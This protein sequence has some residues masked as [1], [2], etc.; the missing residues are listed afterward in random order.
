MIH[1]IE[2]NTEEWFQLR[3]GKITASNFSKIMANNGKAF[4]NPAKDYAARVAI[5]SETF[6]TIETFT[7]DW[8]ERGKMLEDQARELYKGYSFTDVLP[9]GFCEKGRFG[10]SADGLPG[11]GLVEFKYVK[12]NTHFERL[13]KG[14]FD[15]AYKWQIN[16]QMW[17]YDRP[18]CD[19]V[20]YC[21]DFPPEK[22]LYVFRVERNLEEE[23]IMIK[24]LGL[25][26]SEVDHYTKVLQS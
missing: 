17:V 21:P 23:L 4:G 6:V 8:M 2:Q 19:F 16:G 13:L 24:R 14:G 26:A 22:Q 7:N 10:A 3:I 15:T 12:Y 1:E 18:W 5:E 11:P 25:F 20:S 9:G